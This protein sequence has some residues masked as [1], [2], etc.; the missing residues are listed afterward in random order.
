MTWR[1]QLSFRN[2]E[3]SP[4]LDGM[5]K[6]EVYET[7]CRKLEGAIVSSSGTVEK[8]SG[9]T[10]VGDTVFDPDNSVTTDTYTSLACKLI[11]FQYKSDIYALVF[12]VMQDSN[13][14]KFHT[15]RAVINNVLTNA[16]GVT[17]AAG[18][19]PWKQLAKSNLPFKATGTLYTGGNVDKNYLPPGSGSSL[20]NNFTTT[21][22]MHNFTESQ[23]LEL[24]YFQ[25]KDK[26]VVMH[27]DNFPIEVCVEEDKLTTRP[28]EVSRRSPEVRL[29]GDR[30]SV[31]AT[32][33][34]DASG[35]GGFFSTGE[36]VATRDFF[37]NLDKGAIYRIGYMRFHNA[38]NDP[39]SSVYGDH[40]ETGM[41]LWVRISDVISPRKAEV[42][43]LHNYNMDIGSAAFHQMADMFLDPADWDGPYKDSGYAL[44]ASTDARRDLDDPD[45]TQRFFACNMTSVTLPTAISA[46]QLVGCLISENNNTNTDYF[47]QVAECNDSSGSNPSTP[48][49]RAFAINR[50]GPSGSINLS[51]APIY[52]LRDR[53]TDKPVPQVVIKNI[54][55]A[56][57]N[58][59]STTANYAMRTTVPG[60]SV[61]I[62]FGGINS[63]QLVDF[64]PAGH[65]TAWDTYER[66]DQLTPDT[67]AR[68]GGVVHVNGGTF[69]ITSR[70]DNCFLAKCITGPKTTVPTAK[71]SLG[72]SHA[73]GFPSAGASHQ[74]RV[75]F[76]GFKGEPQVVVGSVVDEPERFDLGGTATDGIHFIVNDLR[77][78]RVRFL[79]STEDLIIGTDTGEFSVKGSPLSAVS[80]GVDRQSSYGSASIRPVM[81][82]TYL[83]FVQKDRKT[84]RAMRYIDQ[85][86]RYTSIDISS[87]HEHFF[88][89]ATIQEMVVWETEHDPVVIFRLSD[90]EYL[91]VRVNEN[92]GFFG[93]SRLKLPTGASL[94]PSRNYLQNASGDRT[95]GDDFYIAVDAGDFYR[96]YRYDS[97]LFLDEAVTIDISA[98]SATSLVFPQEFW[99]TSSDTALSAPITHLDGQTVSVVLDGYYRGEFPVAAGTPST[100]NISSLGLSATPTTAVVGKKIEMKVQPRVPEVGA[101]PGATLGKS[102]NYSSVIVNLNNSKT[103][104]VNGY[105]ADGTIF[106]ATADHPTLQGWYEVP[107]TGLYGVQPLLEISSDRPYPVEL[108]GITIDVSV[109]G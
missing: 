6:P 50:S 78:S 23:V 104:Q 93:W 82:G 11:P 30:F 43:T 99:R 25:H 15:I 103:V 38:N 10:F 69:A 58:G 106:T 62:Y 46:N 4:R 47:Y 45:R 75:M 102:K 12:E 66:G 51:A 64:V 8:R 22:G 39:D 18:N 101:P 14:A 68:H 87:D 73:V 3:I 53:K 91:A 95:S 5:A 61:Q 44:D 83:L 96:L 85:R 32:K 36:L 108:A 71:Y 16:T 37:T 98:S 29:V 52:T 2:G 65:E 1:P 92:A 90:G 20:T 77:G 97:T 42:R 40:V 60:D 79:K 7:S 27:A 81:V 55:T 21:F 63:D 76:A 31:S 24:E 84:V 80:A 28:Y 88:R 70:N 67:K 94:C 34:T 74:G 17:T 107:V 13:G 57:T 33:L 49:Y 72:W 56:T 19:G 109:E 9:T 89:D 86:Q 100:I 41:G 48:V 54:N 35:G 105:E 26:V 59:L